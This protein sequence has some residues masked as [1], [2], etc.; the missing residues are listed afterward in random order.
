MG[1]YAGIDNATRTLTTGYIG[2]PTSYTPIE[3]IESSGTQYIDTKYVP[4][5]NTKFVL[6]CNVTQNTQRGYEALFGCRTGSYKTQA[7]NFF[8]RFDNRD[9]PCYNRSGTETTGSNMI[10]GQRITLTTLGQTATW[11]N[12]VNTYS[13][14]TAGTA[15]NCVYSLFLFN[16][17]SSGN[18]DSSYSVMKLYSF[19]VYEDDVLVREYI[20][21][22]DSDVACLYEQVEGKFYYNAGTGI[23]TAGSTTGEPVYTGD[24]A[25]TIVSGYKGAASKY[26]PIEYIQSTG[27]QFIN[28]HY[29]PTS[30][31][32]IEMKVKFVNATTPECLYCARDFNT[33][34]NVQHVFSQFK[35]SNNNWR[36]DYNSNGSD[37][38]HTVDTS[39]L[40]TYTQDKNTFYENDTIISTTSSATFTT[41][42]P[43]YLFASNNSPY[44]NVAALTNFASLKLYSFKIWENDELVRNFI[45]V[46]D[47][48]DVP[49]LYETEEGKLYYSETN[50][51]FLT[52]TNSNTFEVLDYAEF[53]DDNSYI[54][55][56]TTIT[57]NTRIVLKCITGSI[58]YNQTFF[59]TA[60]SLQVKFIVGASGKYAYSF[61]NYSVNWYDLSSSP[62][63]NTQYIY[64]WRGAENK[65]YINSS[66][67][68]LAGN[69]SNDSTDN[70][71]L[72]SIPGKF[73]YCEIYRDGYGLTKLIIPVRLKSNGQV[74]FYDMIG[75]ELCSRGGSGTINAGN[76]IGTERQQSVN[77]SLAKNLILKNYDMMYDYG[78]FGKSGGFDFTAVITGGSKNHLWSAQSHTQNNDNL[79]VSLSQSSTNYDSSAGYLSRNTI[80]MSKYTKIYA[81]SAYTSMGSGTVIVI[82]TLKSGSNNSADQATLNYA[83]QKSGS[84]SSIVVNQPN[85]L[86]DISRPDK[87]RLGFV[88]QSNGWGGTV[89]GRLYVLALFRPDDL[90]ELASI[91]NVSATI[92][93]IL[94]VS[95]E[96]LAN[97]SAVNCMISTCTGDFMISALKNSTFMTQLNSSAYKSK[98]LANPHWNK[99]YTYVTT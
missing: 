17:S 63:N 83:F 49:C 51:I 66:A 26:T 7:Y 68:S 42:N 89:S 44:Q 97:E 33:S 30:N 76:V 9:V 61:S 86:F 59:A 8:S 73:Q 3:Y 79:Y 6:D 54:D 75:K 41:N 92:T 69:A 94:N 71:K 52:N 10:Y 93:D 2:V 1:A 74:A 14:T 37:F 20:P 28:T 38:S 88:F 90:T 67:I 19:K 15:D 24:K 43:I 13:V 77:I 25:R 87:R 21:A 82:E 36:C 18:P 40:Y 27:T 34:N 12:G 35:L 80:D 4:K 58:G 91:L 31:T 57:K 95:N 65:L 70:L 39:T 53:M 99:F 22:K 46:F 60:S 64:D 62:S 55:T 56:E 16:L 32:K 85:L 5:A 98:I 11:T 23:F 47:E 78:K 72:M 81:K 96:L 48:N 29:S 45:P 50:P 84:S